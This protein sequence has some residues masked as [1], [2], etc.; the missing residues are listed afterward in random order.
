MRIGKAL[1]TTYLLVPL[2]L[3]AN[4]A[5]AGETV[6]IRNFVGTIN[7]TN[8]ALDSQVSENKGETKV[9]TQGGFLIDGGLTDIDGDGCRN[10]YVKW[11]WDWGKKERNGTHGGYKNLKDYPIVDISL[12]EDAELVINNAIIFAFGSPNIG[13]AELDLDY[14][15]KVILGDI[16]GGLVVK[17]RGSADLTFG[18]ARDAD[19]ENL[20]SSDVEGGDIS[21]DVVITSRGSGDVELGSLGSLTA[22]IRG[23][24]DVKTADI[25]GDF[26]VGSQGS[27]DVE[28]GDIS[29]NVVI[30]V[31]G[32]GDVETGSLYS[33]AV[34]VEASGSSS[35]D[36]G[37]GQVEDLNVKASGSSDV[38][39]DATATKAVLRAT[40]SSEIYVERVTGVAETKSSHSAD[41]TIDDRG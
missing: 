1:I 10:T 11:S 35:I 32:S 27:G 38:T 21:G 4:V 6:E 5:Q 33:D 15:G 17:A 28:S 39:V 36:L 16:D 25:S 12:P 13:S 7:W 2:S 22:D 9:S 19:I 8:G 23:S 31:R 3:A 30:V 41:I 20:G 14:C 37:G 24:G 34:E 29:G 18:T 40:G 26:A